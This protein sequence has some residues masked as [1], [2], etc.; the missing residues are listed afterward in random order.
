MST[1][2]WFCV[3]HSSLRFTYWSH[4]LISYILQR[5]CG[6]GPHHPGIHAAC[7]ECGM[8]RERSQRRLAQPTGMVEHQNSVVHEPARLVAPL[9][10]RARAAKKPPRGSS[11]ESSRLVDP[12]PSRL[13]PPRDSSLLLDPCSSRQE[14]GCQETRAGSARGTPGLEGLESA[15]LVHN[16]TPE[17]PKCKTLLQNNGQLPTEN[18]DIFP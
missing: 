1:S 13:E 12:C 11:L 18:I 2:G 14:P 17:L 4:L 5:Y 10:S 3:G 7:V 15:R 8:P 6:F 9:D 16:T